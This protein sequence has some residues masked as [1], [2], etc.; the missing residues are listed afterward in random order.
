VRKG[1]KEVKFIIDD[2]NIKAI[3]HLYEYFPVDGVTTNLS[4]RKAKGSHMKF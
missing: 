2:A 4:W 3:K 1:E